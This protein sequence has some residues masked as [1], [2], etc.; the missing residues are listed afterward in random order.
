MEN[1]KVMKPFEVLQYIVLYD[2]NNNLLNGA[3]YYKIYLAAEIPVSNF[4]SII[5]YDIL[6]R[7]MIRTEQK[8]LSVF[9]NC[10][11]LDINNDGSVDV[12]YGPQPPGGKMNN[13]IQT[14][15]GN[16]WNMILR[17]YSPCEKWFNN[18]WTPSSIEEIIISNDN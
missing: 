3:R 15:P 9:K 2:S 18:K 12:F 7:L 17:L 6:S 8:W 5:V 16:Y 1:S 11:N 10:K 14:I 13:W 4:W